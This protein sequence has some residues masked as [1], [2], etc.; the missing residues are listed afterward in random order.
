MPRICLTSAARQLLPNLTAYLIRAFARKFVR[1][2]GGSVCPPRLPVLLGAVAALAIVAWG[3]VTVT[4]QASAAPLVEVDRTVIRQADD[5]RSFAIDFHLKNH[6]EQSEVTLDFGMSGDHDVRLV[7]KTCQLSGSSITGC[8]IFIDPD[9]RKSDGY[10]LKGG[11]YSFFVGVYDASGRFLARHTG[12][13]DVDRKGFLRRLYEPVAIAGLA[14]WNFFIGDDLACLQSPDCP[15]G[16]KALAGVSVFPVGKLVK[17]GKVGGGVVSSVFR[18]GKAATKSIDDLVN[19]AK[20]QLPHVGAVRTGL[21]VG[22]DRLQVLLKSAFDVCTRG[23]RKCYGDLLELNSINALQGMRYKITG[24]YADQS[25]KFRTTIDGV[26]TKA[27]PDAVAVTPTGLRTWVESRT[28]GNLGYDFLRKKARVAKAN[29]F[30]C[31]TLLVHSKQGVMSALSTVT[32]QNLWEK[33][34]QPEGLGFEII[35]MTDGSPKQVIS[36]CH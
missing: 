34:V 36:Q 26:S 33:V 5:S 29:N 10:S 6:G 16:A 28:V 22:Q 1:S 8:R 25:S 23:A 9:R 7:S 18:G 32:S 24:L 21:S 19:I 20:E 17:V 11:D 12:E 3:V 13:I 14:N 15:P 2:I 35:D 4:D 30:D 27:S 31:V